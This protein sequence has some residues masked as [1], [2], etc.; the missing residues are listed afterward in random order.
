MSFS[1]LFKWINYISDYVDSVP[2][3]EVTVKDTE[4][5]SALV[6]AV[7]DQQRESHEGDAY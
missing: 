1:V 2:D 5:T 3:A 4:K 6:I 7:T